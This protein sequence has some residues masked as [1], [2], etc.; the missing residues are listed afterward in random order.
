VDQ[1]LGLV[2]PASQ[3]NPAICTG[4]DTRRVTANALFSATPA[5]SL[6][7]TTGRRFLR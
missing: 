7:A 3:Q 1:A 4:G 2:D 6:S 5:V